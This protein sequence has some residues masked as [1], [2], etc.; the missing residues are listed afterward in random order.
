METWFK[1]F[2]L[3]YFVV[4]VGAAFLWRSYLTWKRT[5]VN[6]YRL[7]SSDSAHDFVGRIFRLALIA[8]ALVILVFVFWSDG[9]RYLVPVFW[10]DSLAIQAVGVL[11]LVTAL[12][13][14][15]VAQIQM[16]NAWRIGIDPAQKT[17]LVQGGLFRISRNPIFLGMRLTSLGLFLVLPNALTLTTLLLSDTLMQIQVRLEEEYLA[18]TFGAA[19]QDYRQHVRRWL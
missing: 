18:S 17:D 11:L 10:L 15:V 9:Y 4:Y 16:G 7:G 13:W 5:G 2:I 1:G 12:V 19:Y 14:V 3:L 8:D 6:P